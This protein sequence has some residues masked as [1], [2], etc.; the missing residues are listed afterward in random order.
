MGIMKVS[1]CRNNKQKDGMR[2]LPIL[3]G[4]I[5][6]YSDLAGRVDNQVYLLLHA[7]SILPG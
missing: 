3:H 4:L 7:E 1:E 2:I 5:D 6:V